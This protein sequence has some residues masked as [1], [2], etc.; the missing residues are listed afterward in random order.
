MR[1]WPWLVYFMSV[2]VL[3]GV[4]AKQAPQRGFN[5]T[6]CEGKTPDRKVQR[7]AHVV[8]ELDHRA[9]M[10][11]RRSAGYAQDQR[12]DEATR[13]DGGC[14]GPRQGDVLEMQ[15]SIRIPTA[16]Y[17]CL[18]DSEPPEP[19]SAC[20]WRGESPADLSHSGANRKAVADATRS[21]KKYPSVEF[22][23]R[24]IAEESC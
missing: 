11:G 7:S 24:A 6:R 12:G 5:A 3:L 4:R 21:I 23:G 1:I 15:L 22:V 20:A 9:G 14:D 17:R 10:I 8:L 19:T 16:A 18:G 13:S 2:R